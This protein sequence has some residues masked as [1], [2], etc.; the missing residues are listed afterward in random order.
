MF[1]SWYIDGRIYYQVIIDKKAPKDGIK[2]LRGIDALK[3]KRIVKPQYEKDKQTGV[4]V[5]TKVE[6]WFEFSPDKNLNASAKLLPTVIPLS[7]ASVFSA[8]GD[9]GWGNSLFS[10]S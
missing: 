1:R 9:L 2:E 7:C 8:S 10:N 5:L 4:P 6:E 3:I